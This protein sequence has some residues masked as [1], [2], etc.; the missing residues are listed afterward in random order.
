MCNDDI[1]GKKGMRSG[2][3][4][5]TYK[6][7]YEELVLFDELELPEKPS[8]MIY[9]CYPESFFFYAALNNTVENRVYL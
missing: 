3:K 6:W 7:L 1:E 2:G 5:A 9:N 8:K 4:V